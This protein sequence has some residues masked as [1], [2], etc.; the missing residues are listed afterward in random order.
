M[1]NEIMRLLTGME[2]LSTVPTVYT[3]L[4]EAIRNSRVSAGHISA[5]ISQDTGLTVRLLRIVNSAF[6]SFPGKIETISRAVI[7][8]G[9]QQLR[10]LALATSIISTFRNVPENHLSVESFWKHSIACGLA[11]RIIASY[12]KEPNIERY[13]VAGIL[14]DVGRMV[15]VMNAPEQAKGAFNRAAKEN[16]PLVEA[17]RNIFGYDHAVVGSSLIHLWQLP[18]SF[19]EIILYHHHPQHASLY[20]TE[21]AVIHIA[22]AVVHAMELG[23]SGEQFIPHVHDEAWRTIGLPIDHLPAVMDLVDKQFNDAVNGFFVH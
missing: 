20:S 13:F 22:D 19:Q 23:N 18:K 6:F 8:V 11:A 14:H 2:K 12:F 9:T 5:I 15:M 16:I 10:D 1:Q 7:I 4:E 17:E 21:T 3:Q